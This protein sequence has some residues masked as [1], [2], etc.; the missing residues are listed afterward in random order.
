MHPFHSRLSQGGIVRFTA[1]EEGLQARTLAAL[2]KLAT[3]TCSERCHEPQGAAPTFMRLW[4]LNLLREMAM[5]FPFGN[6]PASQL[7]SHSVMIL[8]TQDCTVALPQGWGTGR[9]GLH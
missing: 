8:C 3:E 5:T 2:A 6:E 9:R 7:I 4:S 1:S